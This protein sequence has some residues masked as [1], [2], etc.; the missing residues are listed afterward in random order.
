MRAAMLGGWQWNGIWSFQSGAHWSPFD[1]RES[2]LESESPNACSASTFDPVNRV[3]LGGDYNLDGENNDRPSAISNHIH[4]T[5]AQWANGFNLP[6]NFFYAPC[7]GCAG[8]LG[9]NT[10]IGPDYW[11]LDTSLLRNIRVSERFHL[12]VRIEA[13][14]V[15]NHTNFLLGDNNINS[16]SFGIAGGTHP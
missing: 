8:N 12:Q 1:L 13:F 7:L 16:P 5:H 6:P 4:A 9:R 15:F 3:N 10:F 2:R 14:N 11:A